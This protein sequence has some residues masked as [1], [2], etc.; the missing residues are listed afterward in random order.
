MLALTKVYEGPLSWNSI[1]EE[2]DHEDKDYV[3]TPLCIPVLI[4]TVMVTWKKSNMERN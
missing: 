1:S 3:P 2:Y 4:A